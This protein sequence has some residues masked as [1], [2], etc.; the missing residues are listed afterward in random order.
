MKYSLYNKAV[1]L[2]LVIF[3][4]FFIVGISYVDILAMEPVLYQPRILDVEMYPSSC[5]IPPD[6]DVK[7]Y[8][9]LKDIYA[10]LRNATLVY[11]YGTE[12][13][14]E[15]YDSKMDLINGTPADGTYLGIIPSNEHIRNNTRVFY[16]L[17][18]EDTLNYT[19]T[20]QDDY[21]ITTDLYG[22][23]IEGELDSLL[24]QAR[25][26]VATIT[27]PPISDNASG[28]RNVV[29]QYKVSDSY[30]SQHDYFDTCIKEVSCLN[31]SRIQ[32]DKWDGKYAQDIM[33]NFPNETNIA[34]YI[35]A[36][37]SK[38]FS[39]RTN[40]SNLFVDDLPWW[41]SDDYG[42]PLLNNAFLDI[43]IADIN[44]RNLTA[45]LHTKVEIPVVMNSSLDYHRVITLSNPIPY[46]IVISLQPLDTFLIN[47][48]NNTA[49]DREYFPRNSGL[50][51]VGRNGTY[52]E[53]TEVIAS[54]SL[55]TG[56]TSLFG[57]ENLHFSNDPDVQNIHLIGDTS[58]YP[59]DRYYAN[60]FFGMPSEDIKINLENQSFSF[61]NTLK[62][63]W[64]PIIQ[65]VSIYDK[66]YT[67]EFN[68]TIEFKRNYSILTIIIPLI[69]IFYL[70]G[71]IFIFDFK[72]T[73]D[74]VSSRLTLTLGIFALIFTLPEIINSMKPQTTAPSIADSMLSIIIIATIAFTISSIL[75]QHFRYAKMVS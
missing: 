61:G 6:S 32:G 15:K 60:L 34:Y 55:V 17:Q 7:I 56:D 68:L 62:S 49:A 20:Y 19:N 69:S 4:I 25:G 26:Y 29:L 59:F 45:Q 44:P 52:Y 71:S 51:S 5:C 30:I 48:Y 14:E 72:D 57:P 74:L 1:L 22:P 31:M 21:V 39:S 38:G 42:P 9:H 53:R 63:A 35:E 40:V 54:A 27:S 37:D 3:L 33:L 70:L 66:G 24:D 36:F 58:L 10:N 23:L 47:L 73:V 12:E 28:V 18:F 8:A 41:K 64:D 43:F 46:E 65:N 11:S 2:I 13:T 75:R 67:P 16:E 50:T